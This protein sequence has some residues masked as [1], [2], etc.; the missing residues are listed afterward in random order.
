MYVS[1]TKR[2]PVKEKWNWERAFLAFQV[3]DKWRQCSWAQSQ[4][5]PIPDSKEFLQPQPQ[6]LS[7]SPVPILGHPPKTCTWKPLVTGPGKIGAEWF[8]W[9]GRSWFVGPALGAPR[10]RLMMF[11]NVLT[12]SL[13]FFPSLSFSYVHFI[14]WCSINFFTYIGPFCLLNR[15]DSWFSITTIQYLNI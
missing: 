13:S 12:R 9:P 14:F 5:Q 3:F 15:N 10:P 1:W 4:S 11:L 7:L 8:D 2:N 6:C